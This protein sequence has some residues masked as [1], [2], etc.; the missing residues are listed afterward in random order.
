MAMIAM[1][2][3]ISC[4]D[5]AEGNP[6]AACIAT[7]NADGKYDVSCGGAKVGQLY[8]PN[9]D[10][11][12][13]GSQGIPGGDCVLLAVGSDAYQVSCA[14][15]TRGLLEGCHTEQHGDDET[16]ITCLGSSG[17]GLC[18]VGSGVI[19]L[20]D[21]SKSICS[22]GT[23]GTSGLDS[24]GAAVFAESRGQYCGFL[25]KEDFEAGKPTVLKFC[26]T[27][28]APNEADGDNE[29]GWTLAEGDEWKD[30]YCQV[31][32]TEDTDV[33]TGVV[34]QTYA[35]AEPDT[36]GGVLVKTNQTVWK[37]EYCGFASA[38]AVNRTVVSNACGDGG[39]PD[40]DGWGRKY[41]QMKLKT[42]KLTT[43]VGLEDGDFCF[44]GEGK[45]KTPINKADKYTRLN[46]TDDWKDEYCGYA[47][48]LDDS[49]EIASI[50][51]G[52][53]DTSDD[54]NLGPNNINTGWNNDYC[55][56]TSTTVNNKLVDAK[57]TKRV[58]GSTAYCINSDDDEAYKT[59]QSSARLNEGTWLRQYCGF[60][61]AAA[62]GDEI[63]T[64]SRLVG[65]C[66]D[67][68]APNK[69]SWEAGYCQVQPKD[70]LTGHTT[71]VAFAVNADS[72]YCGVADIADASP[73][74]G[75]INKDK[76]QDQY[77]AYA[78]RTDAYKVLTSGP[79]SARVYTWAPVKSVQA[80]KFC[81]K[82]ADGSTATTGQEDYFKRA[83]NSVYAT[84]VPGNDTLISW[85]NQFCQGQ[86]DGTTKLVSPGDSSGTGKVLAAL[87]IICPSDTSS[88]DAD[89]DW[90]KLYP[91]TDAYIPITTSAKISKR[92]SA[93][94]N[95]I[96]E[97]SWKGEYC[98]YNSAADTAANSAKGKFTVIKGKMCGD[99]SGP[100]AVRAAVT[101]QPKWL[102]EYCQ[103]TSSDDPSTVRVA[104]GKLDG[105]NWVKNSNDIYC[106]PDNDTFRNAPATNRLNE[107]SWKGE[108]CFTGNSKV[109]KGKCLAG[110][111]PVGY[112]S[113]NKFGTGT[114]GTCEIP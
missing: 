76:W 9:G 81:D 5:G 75:T 77:C 43:T 111:Q 87:G 68:E 36:C 107:G 113:T 73:N 94:S 66:D 6:G 109:E 11:G 21:P 39:F 47:S 25:S 27:D 104:T 13:T 12:Q 98:G 58:G 85:G 80:K 8:T 83:P 90:S 61:S 112:T 110:W 35:V 15:V 101:N 16:L 28:G 53:C 7:A 65:I 41:C 106:G 92:Y 102:N 55:Q 56:G 17:I 57:T 84:R 48:A 79:A 72:I 3:T 93:T 67:G 26:G 50:R 42:D 91:L 49:L 52:N 69:D 64:R 23:V 40:D 103:A 22:S 60:A 70:S 46:V 82:G 108:Y 38:T 34:V 37:G 29:T 95:F 1:V 33:G 89:G 96:N 24:C 31:T 51:T 10:K 78:S 97:G 74:S 32:R 63:K 45:E 4:S 86:S 62:D 2:F 71:K 59:A 88:A 18:D 44:T 14:G 54:E 19:E 30:E 100:N 20:F 114:A 99:N 105:A